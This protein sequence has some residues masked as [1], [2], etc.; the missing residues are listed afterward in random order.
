M[1]SMFIIFSKYSKT[2]HLDGN[3]ITTFNHLIDSRS[4][5]QLLIPINAK[6]THFISKQRSHP[7]HQQRNNSVIFII[8]TA[9]PEGSKSFAMS[10]QIKT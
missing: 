7:A 6:C 8:Y 3:N 2:G 10:M 9:I 4:S 1:L 5:S